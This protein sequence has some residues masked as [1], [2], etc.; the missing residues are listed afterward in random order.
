MLKIRY[1]FG[2]IT[3]GNPRGYGQNARGFMHSEPRT[4]P[5]FRRGGKEGFDLRK[6]ICICS[7][8][9]VLTVFFTSCEGITGDPPSD[10]PHRETS[11]HTETAQT[12]APMPAAAAVMGDI[13]IDKSS[14][15]MRAKD[16]LMKGKTVELDS[17]V[18]E[19]AEEQLLL[20]Q[21]KGTSQDIPKEQ[22]EDMRKSGQEGYEAHKEENDAF[23]KKY[24]LSKEECLEMDLAWKI[25]VMARGRYMTLISDEL[26]AEYKQKY[27]TD[28]TDDPEK[29]LQ[30]FNKRIEQMVAALPAVTYNSREIDA[31]AAS[32][33][34]WRQGV[35]DSVALPDVLLSYG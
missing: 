13:Q 28:Q 9:A 18:L 3:G 26:L 33:E 16:K 1:V 30:L 35:D 27:G 7:I 11:V 23:I 17:L 6:T 34:A 2:G 4:M 12:S 10:L 21:I 25:G 32:L 8:W 24:N 14:L 20:N 15:E 5:R 29:L 31:M 22:Y 19:L